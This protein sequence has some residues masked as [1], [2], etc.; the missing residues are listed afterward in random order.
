MQDA[1]GFSG[2]TIAKRSYSFVRGSLGEAARIGSVWVAILTIFAML[3]TVVND[4]L[5]SDDLI[6]W[7]SIGVAI[8]VSVAFFASVAVTWHRFVLRGERAGLLHINGPRTLSYMALLI[9]FYGIVIA[10]FVL[11]TYF[12]TEYFTAG[13]ESGMLFFVAAV[14]ALCLWGLSARF[15]LRLPAIAI[16]DDRMTLQESWSTTKD[17]WPGLL[18]G[19]IVAAL[20]PLVAEIAFGLASEEL[21][22]YP[23]AEIA[24]IAISSAFSIA[25]VLLYA[26]FL[27]LSYQWLVGDTSD[28][29]D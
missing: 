10:P 21:S 12:I 15:A 11:T 28:V 6:T 24:A 2:W 7:A 16:D 13:L 29:F 26:T 5:P 23:G 18:W 27:S 20:P 8:V 9:A 22:N 17:L 19:T 4:H 3:Q 1:A 14:A 25:G